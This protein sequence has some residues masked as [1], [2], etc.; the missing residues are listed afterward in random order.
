MI[1]ADKILENQYTKGNEYIDSTGKYYQ[2]YYC[3]VL[4]SKY[5]AGKTFTP[6]SKELSK[7][8][9]APKATNPTSLP[10][11]NTTTRYFLKKINVFPISIK[12]VNEQTY[13]TYIND[14][15]YQSVILVRGTVFEGSPELDQAEAQMPGLKAFLSA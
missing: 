1:P 3:V 9:I 15:L 10:P 2:G 12:E 8:T 11:Q 14:P 4:G 13:N 6:Q 5:Y 7:V